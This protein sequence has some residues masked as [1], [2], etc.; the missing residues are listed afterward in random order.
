M[1]KKLT[2]LD[3][4][5]LELDAKW[6]GSLWAFTV[7]LKGSFVGLGIATA[8]EAGYTPVPLQ[9]CHGDDYH[10]M[11]AH[12]DE[13]NQAWLGLDKD[14]ALR[15]VCSSMAQGRVQS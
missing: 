3:R 13:L 9:R 8:N 5:E 2:D 1:L 10:A 11:V 7:V 4:A 15:V 6:A 12:A 14:A